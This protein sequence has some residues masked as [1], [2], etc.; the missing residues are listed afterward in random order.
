MADLHPLERL[1]PSLLDRLTDD[2]PQSTVESRHQRVLSL[3]RLREGVIRDV[4]WLLNARCRSTSLDRYPNVSDSV[5][6]YGIPELSG[7][8]ASGVD[9]RQ[10]ELD[11]AAAI[12]RFEPRLISNTVSVAVT[13]STTADHNAVQFEIKAQ[14]WAEPAAQNLLLRTELDLETGDMSVDDYDIQ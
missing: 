6:N 11:V 2:D 4:G 3:E 8:A 7:T 10:L 9:R 1:Q 5:L 14:L 12:R 13:K